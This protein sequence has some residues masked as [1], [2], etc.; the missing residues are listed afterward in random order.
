MAL[1]LILFCFAGHPVYPTLLQTMEQ[2]EDSGKVILVSFLVVFSIY[3]LTGIVGYGFF[4]QAT[5]ESFTMNLGKDLNGEPISTPLSACSEFFATLLM[6]FNKQV[7]YPLLVMALVA[8]LA[9]PVDAPTGVGPGTAEEFEMISKDSTPIKAGEPFDVEVLP[10]M[11]ERLSVELESAPDRIEGDGMLTRQKSLGWGSVMVLSAQS[12]VSHWSRS[13][14]YDR[15][16]DHHASIRG[17]DKA[18]SMPLPSTDPIEDD[19]VA[20]S[21]DESMDYGTVQK[22]KANDWHGS[23]GPQLMFLQNRRAI[24]LLVVLVSICIALLLRKHYAAVS[25]LVGSA[26]TVISSVFF[27]IIFDANILQ[28]QRKA[29]STPFEAALIN[30]RYI[31]IA[32]IGLF[33]GVIGSSGSVCD[34]VGATSGLCAV[35]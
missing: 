15:A 19:E 7:S 13:A 11:M 14:S 32:C 5:G 12:S 33:A 21:E 2:P 29:E 26:C 1:G 27:P 22:T 20:S 6:T 30:V 25:S 4:G 24:S 3:A 16:A 23:K 28:K 8:V 18:N 10:P 17:F 34:F 9:G 31:V 35:V